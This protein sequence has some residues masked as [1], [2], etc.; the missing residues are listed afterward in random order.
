LLRALLGVIPFEGKIWWKEKINFGYV[1]QRLPFVKDFPLSV[2]E[3]FQIK[4]IGKEKTI[5]ILKEFGFEKNILKKKMGNLSSGQFQRILVAW[6]L[7][8]EPDV[9]LFD[10]PT[11][12]IDILG[13]ETIYKILKRLKKEKKLTLILVTHDLSCVFKFSDYVICLNRCPVCQGVPREV[14]TPESLEKLYG[15]EVKFY[16]HHEH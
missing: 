6:A 15:T 11:A 5:E 12:G 3:F 14:L 7:C 16:T 13:K 10:E 1:P 9:L 8:E 4:N 2:E